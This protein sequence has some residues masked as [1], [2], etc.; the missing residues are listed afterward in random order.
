MKPVISKELKRYNYLFGETSAIYHE[1]YL[2]LGLSDS[3]AMMPEQADG[4][5]CSSQ[6]G[7][8]RHGLSGD[9]R[10]QT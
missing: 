2:K 7:G 6:A 5:F 10:F 9:V 8:R 3:A 1:M 4:Q